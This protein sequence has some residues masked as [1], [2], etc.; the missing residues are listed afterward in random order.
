MIDRSMIETIVLEV[1]R[2][3]ESEGKTEV[4]SDQPKLLIVGDASWIF[5]NTLEKLKQNWDL[6]FAREPKIEDCESVE[7]IIFF[8]ASQDLIVK[9][10]LGI[11]D[12]P[13]SIL[14]AH[15]LLTGKKGTIVP[16]P[17]LEEHLLAKKGPS[18]ES[19]YIQKL[20]NYIEELNSFGVKVE[21]IDDFANLGKGSQKAEP[22]PQLM[23]TSANAG[24]KKLLTQRDVQD[25]KT[26]QIF[27]CKNTIITPS[28]RDAARE[29]GKSIIVAE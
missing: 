21:S 19:K 26:E 17:T 11:A 25:T 9:G 22:V 8:R 27:V 29:L 23:P 3:L 10:A 15:C 14:L 7:H 2:A 24:K 20:L 1:I 5:E 4:T 12:T 13:D 18:S 16:E 6:N 28:A